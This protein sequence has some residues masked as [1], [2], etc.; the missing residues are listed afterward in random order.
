VGIFGRAEEEEG[1]P[2]R[3]ARA[4][5]AMEGWG[6]EG[7]E[8][9]RGVPVRGERGDCG[10]KCEQLFGILHIIEVVCELENV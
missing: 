1:A 10:E 5:G 3:G 7:W 2:T 4:G 9:G 8:G 6:A